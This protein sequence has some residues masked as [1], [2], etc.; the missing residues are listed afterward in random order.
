M[1]LQP[2]DGAN[3]V[4]LPDGRQCWEKETKSFGG[5]EITVSYQYSVELGDLPT[6]YYGRVLN[7]KVM[8]PDGR[9]N[10]VVTFFPQSPALVD[11][12]RA[13][14]QQGWAVFSEGTAV[15]GSRKRI[16]TVGYLAICA[17][18]LELLKRIKP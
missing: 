3:R 14:M 5:S 15:A 10:E 4:L 6:D 17:D 7:L 1:T 12:V 13:M 9:W 18:I 8:A 11:R 2:Y 16:Y